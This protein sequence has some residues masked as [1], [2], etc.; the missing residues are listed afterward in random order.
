MDVYNCRLKCISFKDVDD[1]CM[2][3]FMVAARGA[4]HMFYATS[5]AE[6][7]KWF[8]EL[9]ECSILVDLKEYLTVRKLLGLGNSA[10]VHRCERISNPGKQYALKT[11]DKNWIRQDPVNQVSVSMWSIGLLPIMVL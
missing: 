8:E 10:R 2:Y 1:N 9:K 6:R 5:K 3:G 11:I 7:D 4:S